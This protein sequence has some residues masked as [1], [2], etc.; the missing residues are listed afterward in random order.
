MRDL[1]TRNDAMLTNRD[2]EAIDKVVY[3][4][5][6]EELKARTLVN[7]K[8]DIHPGAETYSYDKLTRR[9]A[10]KIFAHGADDVPLVDADLDRATVKIYSIVAGFRVTVQEKRAAQMAGKPIETT[11]AETAR[12]AVA[13][14]E[15]SIFFQG[16]DAYGIEGILNATGIQTYALPNGAGGKTTWADKTPMEIVADIRNARAKV[17]KIEGMNADTLVLTPDAYE[18]L[19]RPISDYNTNTIMSYLEEQKWFRRIIQDKALVGAGTGETDCFLLFDSS[20][21][22]IELGIPMDITRYDPV[23]LPNLSEQINLEERTTGAIIRFPS[24]I[25]RADGC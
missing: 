20:K 23:V 24:A 25:C 15:N 6:E 2:L 5:K 4:A 17:N 1:A 11:K 19:S 18:E 3:E 8:T 12:K 21:E 7:L 14:K 10:A 16:D 22:N 9:G 13:I